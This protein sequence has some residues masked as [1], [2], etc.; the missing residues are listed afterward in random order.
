M[1]FQGGWGSNAGLCFLYEL[2]EGCSAEC[3]VGIEGDVSCRASGKRGHRMMTCSV[4][5]KGSGYGVS[6]F[7]K[8]TN[9]RIKN[10]P[11]GLRR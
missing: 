5:W 2:C 3:G 9:R 6:V 11:G 4:V 1:V 7:S 8:E 10:K